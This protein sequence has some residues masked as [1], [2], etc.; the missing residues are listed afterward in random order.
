MSSKI[1]HSFSSTENISLI[2]YSI[3]KIN[4]PIANQSVV[5]DTIFDYPFNGTRSPTYG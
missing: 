4:N 2:P 3:S 1:R 5:A